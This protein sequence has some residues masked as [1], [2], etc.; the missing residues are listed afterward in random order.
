MAISFRSNRR[1]HKQGSR[2]PFRGCQP[3]PT[4]LCGSQNVSQRF[5]PGS[6]VIPPIFPS[7]P[8]LLHLWRQLE[9]EGQATTGHHRRGSQRH[10]GSQ[11]GT[12]YHGG[13]EISGKAGGA[14]RAIGQPSHT[15]GGRCRV[16]EEHRHQQGPCGVI[17]IEK[18]EMRVCLRFVTNEGVYWG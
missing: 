10:S 17:A 18:K 13:T 3:L 9:A 4:Q 11:A 14:D 5:L 1:G 8:S 2:L 16:L 15:V 7:R 6:A 12:E